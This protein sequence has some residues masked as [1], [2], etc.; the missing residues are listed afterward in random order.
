MPA[1]KGFDNRVPLCASS[2]SRKLMYEVDYAFLAPEDRE[3]IK[4]PLSPVRLKRTLNDEE[5]P[6][7]MTVRQKN[8]T[9]A[10]GSPFISHMPKDK[11]EHYLFT[12]GSVKEPQ[13]PYLLM[14]MALTSK[15]G[16]I[17]SPI[18]PS[19]N[20]R[21]LHIPRKVATIEDFNGS[22]HEDC[23][24]T[25]DRNSIST[26]TVDK[27][28]MPRIEIPKQSEKNRGEK[29]QQL[30]NISDSDQWSMSNKYEESDQ[31]VM[32][33]SHTPSAQL[34]ASNACATPGSMIS[35]LSDRD[36]MTPLYTDRDSLPTGG[37]G[38]YGDFEDDQISGGSINEDEYIL[39]EPI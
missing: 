26:A 22:Y 39:D 9:R 18:K 21:N 31:L 15:L 16:K 37:S 30:V 17:V 38:I 19:Q 14:E 33:S 2:R 7:V 20:S 3:G 12:I 10:R 32:L 28:S 27:Y 35:D 8:E 11:K 29:Q 1:L 34:L 23:M 4:R 5:S 25:S 24:R 6:I 36:T 13:D